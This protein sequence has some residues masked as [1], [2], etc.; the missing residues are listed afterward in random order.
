[1]KIIRESK[2]EKYRGIRNH[3][4]DSDSWKARCTARKYRVPTSFLH[5]KRFIINSNGFNDSGRDSEEIAASLNVRVYS[6]IFY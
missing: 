6:K 2:A 3:I 5:K 4:F 1:M